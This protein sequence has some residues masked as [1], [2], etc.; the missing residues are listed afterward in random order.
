MINVKTT[1]NSIKLLTKD[2]Y[3]DD[4]I[5][6]TFEGGSGGK[7]VR[8]EVT[9][10]MGIQDTIIIR[11]HIYSNEETLSY[12]DA[13]RI[14][15]C[16]GGE[17]SCVIKYYGREDYIFNGCFEI[18]YD[19]SAKKVTHLTATGTGYSPS[20]GDFAPILFALYY[21]GEDVSFTLGFADSAYSEQ[22]QTDGVYI[23]EIL[24]VEV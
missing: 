6:V 3:C 20:G 12:D 1:E 5:N 16:T 21:N 22:Y 8:N 18:S 4:D 19:F 23:D 24:D 9:I 17:N 7:L 11:T 10:D 14:L 13:F 2:K 15:S